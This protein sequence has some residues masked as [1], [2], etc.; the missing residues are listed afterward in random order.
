M[1]YIADLRRWGKG[2]QEEVS[3]IP[4]RK[5]NYKKKTSL[6][7]KKVSCLSLSILLKSA[8]ENI[9]NS[10]PNFIYLSNGVKNTT[11]LLPLGFFV[12]IKLVNIDI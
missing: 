7:I 11:Y 2:T 8:L 5:T 10:A 6:L 1:W 12:R 9:F 3:F 4:K